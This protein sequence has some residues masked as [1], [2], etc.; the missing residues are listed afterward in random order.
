MKNSLRATLVVAGTA[1]AVLT[2]AIPA[3]AGNSDPLAPMRAGGSLTYVCNNLWGVGDWFTVG[4][5]DGYTHQYRV[6]NVYD[7]THETRL[8]LAVFTGDSPYRRVG[9]VSVYCL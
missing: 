6:D 3:L 9:D 1:L 8:D 7:N 4:A 5:N 2:T